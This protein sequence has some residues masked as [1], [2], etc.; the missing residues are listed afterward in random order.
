MNE[1]GNTISRV[2][3]SLID[4]TNVLTSSFGAIAPRFSGWISATT[5]FLLLYMISSSTKLGTSVFYR[6][7]FM[8]SLTDLLT[9]IAMGLT[10]LPMP[11]DNEDVDDYGFEGTRLG[12]ISTCTA[13]GFFFLFGKIASSSYL[14][15]VCAYY[16]C[17]ISY[18]MT[19]AKIVK[20]FEAILH[21]SALVSAGAIAIP[22]L[23]L[24]QY[25]A[26]PS[27]AWCTV[28][29]LPNWCT[30]LMDCKRGTLCRD[31]LLDTI[32]ISFLVILYAVIIV[33]L[34][35][36]IRKVLE[37]NNQVEAYLERMGTGISPDLAREIQKKKQAANIATFQAVAYVTM[38]SLTVLFQVFT[39]ARYIKGD[40]GLA[41]F[42]KMKLIF[43]P[44]QGLFNFIIFV[45]GNVVILRLS[46]PNRSTWDT[47]KNLFCLKNLD[48]EFDITGIKF[49]NDSD[50]Y[51]EPII[52]QADDTTDEE[53]DLSSMNIRTVDFSAAV[54]S[55][56]SPISS[57]LETNSHRTTQNNSITH[58]K[59]GIHDSISP[60]PKS[61]PSV[62]LNIRR[63]G[64]K[65]TNMTTIQDTDIKDEDAAALLSNKSDEVQQSTSTADKKPKKSKLNIK[66]RGGE[67]VKKMVRT[68][69]D[70]VNS[71]VDDI[72]SSHQ[73]ERLEPLESV[74]SQALSF[75]ESGE[76]NAENGKGAENSNK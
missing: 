11:Q 13:Q 74:E 16:A 37:Q 39:A 33:A 41:T 26:T 70:E 22:F 19:E 65:M 34:H 5:S 47:I 45:T 49:V 10:T 56:M 57:L 36:V 23:F 6:L 66:R 20:D 69:V 8:M 62:Q 21:I 76:L 12:S 50:G 55:M 9:S 3:S 75:I 38:F 32:F 4:G 28:R 7:M 24:K 72:Q 2:T 29:R 15:T 60:L 43:Q 42:K 71:A 14:A 46:D 53:D 1:S 40:T 18:S 67:K 30:D 27:E 25:N 31:M 54:S 73:Q 17:S 61:K 64:G 35:K 63:R 48:D 44:L 58:N 59:T 68:N 52:I 51:P